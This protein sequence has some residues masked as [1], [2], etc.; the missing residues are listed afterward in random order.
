MVAL[1]SVARPLQMNVVGALLI[2]L[3]G[4]LFVTVSS[5]LTGEVGSSSN[6]ISGMT[7][8][9]LLLT[10]LAFLAKG[11][12]GPE[13]YVTALSVG[14]IVCIAS[15]NGGTT[16]QDLKT[17]FLVGG[18]PRA[19]QVAILIGATASALVLG[20][21]LL[22]LNQ[23]STVYVRA[24]EVAGAPTVALPSP[25]VTEREG[26]RGHQ[27]G[28]DAREYWV[29]HQ[30]DPRGG[31]ARKFLL[32]DTGK[33][34]WWVDPG[35]NGTVT[36][37]PGG[38]EVQKFEA[39]K[40]VLV[41]YIIKGIL[42]R[43][44]P[45]DLVLMGVMI[46]LVLELCGIPSLA[47][48]VGVYLPIAVSMP[49]FVGGMLRWLADRLDRHRH[50]SAGM[51]EEEMAAEGD[52]SPG[53]LMASGYIAGGSIAGIVVAL[54][55]ARFPGVA[56]GVTRWMSQHNPMYEGPRSDAWSLVPF[57][58]ICLLLFLAARRRFLAR[59]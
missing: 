38:L 29:Y 56:A 30:P 10:C 41:S 4:F 37:L 28:E 35:I 13:Y 53:V 16:S 1:I 2:V 57:G 26:L 32:D 19:Q 46:A 52:K 24:S 48:A 36:R 22:T 6:P 44:L 20:P 5:R 49:I 11:W 55:E 12:T 50:R 9:T 45:W 27:R 39:P 18:T 54:V 15:S 31:A 3:L 47:F 8:A 21:V 42:D 40:A 7:I 33:A 51:S 34:A 17:G 23:A 25:L 43:K 14:A 58:V 59:G